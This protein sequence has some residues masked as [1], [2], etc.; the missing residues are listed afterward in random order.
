MKEA[1]AFQCQGLRG[2]YSDGM[3][4]GAFVLS[5]QEANFK[6]ALGAVQAEGDES[7]IKVTRLRG[8]YFIK[9]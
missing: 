2:Y 5:L 9:T 4:L 6:L 3:Q 7:R 8:S 1:V